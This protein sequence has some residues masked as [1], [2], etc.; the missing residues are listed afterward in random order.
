MGSL[1]FNACPGF[2][3]RLQERDPQVV[4]IMGAPGACVKM[5]LR[6]RRWLCSWGWADTKPTRGLAGCFMG[7]GDRVDDILTI[8]RDWPEVAIGKGDL[9]I[10]EGVRAN[11]LYV[12]KRGAFDVVRNGVRIVQIRDPGAFLG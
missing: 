6:P 3:H 1:L 2:G 12:L 4:R 9:L 8:C 10:E 5:C 7:R 11:R